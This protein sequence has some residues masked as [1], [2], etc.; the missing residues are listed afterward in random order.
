[1]HKICRFDLFWA[2]N[3]C[4]RELIDTAGF[5]LKNGSIFFIF[6][7]IWCEMPPGVLS[8]VKLNIVVGHSLSHNVSNNPNSTNQIISDYLCHNQNCL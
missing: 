8:G 5:S 1:M 7:G 3:M 6:A 2:K 4:D